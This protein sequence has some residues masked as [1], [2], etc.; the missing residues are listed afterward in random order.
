MIRVR[1]G[2]NGERCLIRIEHL[3]PLK[4]PARTFPYPRSNERTVSSMQGSTTRDLLDAAA[5][6]VAQR[7]RLG[8]RPAKAKVHDMPLAD[9]VKL[10]PVRV[11]LYE[12]ARSVA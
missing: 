12:A 2:E 8:M 11:M 6:Y 3:T 4:I 1:D 7:D 9:L 5:H 10:P